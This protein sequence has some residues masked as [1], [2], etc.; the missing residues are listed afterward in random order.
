[1]ATPGQDSTARAADAPGAAIGESVPPGE[2]DAIAAIVRGIEDQVRA[3]AKSGPAHRDAHAKAHGCVRAEFRVLD[4]LPAALRVGIFA[5]PRTFS[6]WIRF[7]NGSG[8]PQRDSIGDGRGMAIKLM[9]V[10]ES[11]STTQDFLMINHPAFFV[12]NAVDYVDFQKASNPLWFFFPGINPFHLRL[13]EFW[14]ALAI[15]RR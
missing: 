6:A 9:G 5:Q 11:A 15:R 1:V 13:K 12:R 8:T 10:T 14:I 4:D 2:A 3:A 7:S